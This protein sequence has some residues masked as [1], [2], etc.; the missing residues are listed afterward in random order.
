MFTP[1]R[2]PGSLLLL[3]FLLLLPLS[4]FAADPTP[5]DLYKE[6]KAFKLGQ[7]SIKVQDF[8]L[9]RDSLRFV[10]TGDFYFS[11]TAGGVYGAVFL[12]QGRLKTEPRFVFEAESIKRFLDTTAVE[13]TFTK[14]VLRFTDDTH[15]KLAG[16]PA[17]GAAPQEAQSLASDLDEHLTR[18]TGL[19]IAA[20]L[21]LAIVN[22]DNPG[23][24]YAELD[25][26]NRGRLSVLL[27]HQARVPATVFDINGGEKGMIFRYAG[28]QYG[29]DV[30]TAFYSMQD[31]QRGNV[32]YSDAFDL[33][34]I[35]TYRMD[36]DL[37]DPG[38]WLR[39]QTSMELV[40]LSDNVHVVPMQLN[41]GLGESDNERRNKGVRVVSA[42][43]E[44]GKPVGVIQEEWETGVSLILPAPLARGQS[45][46]VNL[47]LEGRDSLW[48]WGSQFHYPRSTTSWYPRHG[49]LARS[50]FQ[51]TFRHDK[52]DRIASIGRRVR[53]GAAEG[54]EWVTE[55]EVTDPVA[56]ITFVCGPFQRHA[57]DTDV[58]GKKI[59][60]EYYSP[61]GSIAAVKEDFILAEV[62]NAVRYFDN[63]FGDYPY[64]RLGGAY[65]P[66][67]FGQG[68]PTLLLLPVRGTAD[69][70]EFA[71]LAHENAHQ[72]WGNIVGWRSYRDQWLSE[73]F[74]EYSGVL[75]T[76][77]RSSSKNALELIKEMRQEMLEIPT[78]STGVAKTKL[79][80]TGPLI[81]GYRLNSSRSRGA[82]ELI[83]S[84][85]ALVLRML[86]YLL[87]DPETADDKAFFAMMKDF[88][89]RH[90]NGVATSESFIQ[91]AGEHFANSPLGRKYQLKDL[92]WFLAQWVYQ[93]GLPSYRLDY[94]VEARE[95]G[96]FAVRG[97]LLQENV[98][99]NWFMILPLI[100]EFSGGRQ[101]R[102]SIYAIGP[103]TNIELRLPEKPQ[104]VR[105]DP[106]LWI[107][108]EKTSESGK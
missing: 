46:R 93:T 14:A 84:K 36:V 62:G 19:N 58:G 108:S 71:F 41:Q 98:N 102:T 11:E 67:N 79:H 18:E 44:D 48:S 1:S 15:Q 21:L 4:A 107:L 68:F 76:G 20:R 56:L 92:N 43:T 78:T 10:F 101:A 32:S 17:A 57:E 2:Y 59:P 23:F 38:N 86:H 80:E 70:Y 53:E 30:W 74:A 6:L 82:A 64:G 96:G 83:Y 28:I 9:D 66:T 81:L 33:V 12:G 5:E 50:K 72:W 27:D 52:T 91:V 75:Y 39:M 24:F 77:L 29:I 34:S 61:P 90:R 103:K 87:S 73:G 7:T 16:Q 51:M 97:T 42:A 65:F 25:G 60:I 88:V 22:K 49:Y 94:R 69:R 54:N 35:P 45:V 26:G 63:L 3:S 85:G 55:W 47:K 95:G 37:R 100:A 13:T 106:D 99:E 31:L 40:A 89:E 105:L 8:T 104:R